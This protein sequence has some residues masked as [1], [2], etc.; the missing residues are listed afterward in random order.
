MHS[1]EQLEKQ[2]VGL[3]LPKY[4]VDEIDEFTEQ[5]SLNRTDIIMEALKSYI[6]E[7]K[8]KTFYDNFEQGVK[9]L[10]NILDGKVDTSE[11]TTLDELIDE[12]E[13][14]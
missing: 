2:Q 14:S 12:L 3:R 9:E 7:Q 4:L 5:F 10:K 6:S 1:L 11:L 8:E 13:H